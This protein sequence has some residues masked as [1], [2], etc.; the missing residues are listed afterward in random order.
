[1]AYTPTVWKSGDIVTSTKLNK[2]ETAVKDVTDTA[3]AAAVAANILKH[4]TIS[5]NGDTGVET[6]DTKAKAAYDAMKAGTVYAT[7]TVDTTTDL[8][9]G[10]IASYDTSDGYTFYLLG[11]EKAFVAATDDDY[12]TYTPNPAE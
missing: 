10:M 11:V 9:N 1:M 5:V 8:Y 6:F 7:R 4:V 3:S 2:L 12:P